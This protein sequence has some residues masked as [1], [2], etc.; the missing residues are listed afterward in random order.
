MSGSKKP[1]FD[2]DD[3]HRRLAELKDRR[4]DTQKQAD[5]AAVTAAAEAATAATE[6]KKKAEEDRRKAAKK[7]ERT[8]QKHRDSA[9]AVQTFV[10]RVDRALGELLTATPDEERA[11]LDNARPLLMAYFNAPYTFRADP[12]T[13]PITITRFAAQRVRAAGDGHAH[14]AETL[15]QK[16]HT[17]RDAYD[18]HAH[19]V[20]LTPGQKATMARG[21][22]AEGDPIILRKGGRRRTRKARRRHR[23][24]KTHRRRRR[25][26]TRTRR[27]RRKHSRHPKKRQASKTRKGR[28]DFVTHKGDKAYNRSGHRQYRRH[29]PYRRT[30]RRRRR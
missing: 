24:R 6:A 9:R 16:V 18:L 3:M 7:S 14:Q 12:Y 23:R 28:L 11:A 30:R 25:K 15:A 22:V 26:K 29:R 5:A 10:D 8:L 1:K 4:S 17:L 27:R 21:G 13:E 19:G 2:L 20:E